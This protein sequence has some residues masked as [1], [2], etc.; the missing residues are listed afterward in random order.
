MAIV[1][2]PRNFPR[3][4]FGVFGACLVGNG[5][6]LV[7]NSSHALRTEK[8]GRRSLIFENIGLYGAF[9]RAARR[10]PRGARVV[11]PRSQR[12]HSSP[13]QKLFSPPGD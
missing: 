3:S 7:E 4:D 5:N 9:G 13:V 11:A 12:D 6:D 2:P 10:P 8:A 1:S